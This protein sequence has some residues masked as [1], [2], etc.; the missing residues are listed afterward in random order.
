MPVIAN[1]DIVDAA[2]ARARAGACRARRRDGRARGAGA[3]PGSW[4][5]SRQAARHARARR[6][7]GPALADLVAGHYDAML[8][9]YGADLGARVARKHLGWYMDGPERPPR[10]ARA[11]LTAQ[12]R[13]RCWR[14]LPDALRHREGRA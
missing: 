9:F 5:R 8:A 4:P 10:C 13:A 12:D 3:G 14:L 11:M 6:A 1:G 7:A 2:D